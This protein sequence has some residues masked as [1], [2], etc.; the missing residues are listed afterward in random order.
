[1]PSSWHSKPHLNASERLALTK[2]KS[3]GSIQNGA[4]FC[5]VLYATR[6]ASP[7]WP[8]SAPYSTDTTSMSYNKVY[9]EPLQCHCSK[10]SSGSRVWSC[11][12]SGQWKLLPLNSTWAETTL[13]FFSVQMSAINLGDGYLIP[14]KASGVKL[15][16]QRYIHIFSSWETPQLPDNLN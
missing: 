13:R 7:R 1:M 15:K 4:K 10:H 11:T 9:H 16:R 5:I 3:F 12:S 8:H 14:R 6:M 2:H